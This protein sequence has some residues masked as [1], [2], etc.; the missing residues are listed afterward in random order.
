VTLEEWCQYSTGNSKREAMRTLKG[1]KLTIFVMRDACV[2]IVQEEERRTCRSQGS[3]YD[4][5][6]ST[7][8]HLPAKAKEASA[9]K[10]HHKPK[11]SSV[12]PSFRDPAIN[13]L[14]VT[15]NLVLS[16]SDLGIVLL[17]MLLVIT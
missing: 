1:Q 17:V 13:V 11:Q 2:Q 10:S 3:S 6:Y 15:N 12:S 5:L 14:H 16:Y 4:V 8:S 9:Q 7:R